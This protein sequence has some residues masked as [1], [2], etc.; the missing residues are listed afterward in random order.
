MFDALCDC[1]DESLAYI[2]KGW[3]SSCGASLMIY[4][5]YLESNVL[6]HGLAGQTRKPNRKLKNRTHNFEIST[7]TNYLNIGNIFL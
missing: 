1:L 6:F 5:R 7:N 3:L 2:S 4:Y